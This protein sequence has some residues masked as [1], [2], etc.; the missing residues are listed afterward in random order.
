[1]TVLKRKQTPKTIKLEQFLIELQIIKILEP[2]I[3]H[4]LLEVFD[5]H[6]KEKRLKK[7]VQTFSSI[8]KTLWRLFCFFSLRK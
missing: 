5:F 2:L 4:V 6:Y 8:D 7:N 3:F 1:M